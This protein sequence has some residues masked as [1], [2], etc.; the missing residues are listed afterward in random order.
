LSNI[1]GLKMEKLNTIARIKSNILGSINSEAI[2]AWSSEEDEFRVF[3]KP[4]T[5]AEKQKIQKHA[6]DDQETT[7]YTII[8]KALDENGNNLFT[9]ADKVQLMN[10][11][12][13]AEIEEIALKILT[14]GDAGSLGN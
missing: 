14:A 7:V 12:P 8:F 10:T 9:I 5:L 1:S 11:I 3:W 2:A 13:S 6:R 4:I